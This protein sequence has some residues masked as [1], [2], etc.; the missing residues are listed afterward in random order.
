MKYFELVQ[1]CYIICCLKDEFEVDFQQIWDLR[2]NISFGW[3]TLLLLSVTTLC[4]CYQS[5]RFVAVIS[6][7]TL[8]LLSVNTLCCCYQSLHFVAVISHYTLLLLS[9]TFIALL[10]ASV[11]AVIYSIVG[12]AVSFVRGNDD[13]WNT[14]IAATTTGI[15]YCM[16][17]K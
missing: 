12:V 2:S 4:C 7:Y 15:L 11:S 6:H 17:S 9:V 1:N 14:G 5:L 10:Y 8:L 3:Y 13:H 16:P